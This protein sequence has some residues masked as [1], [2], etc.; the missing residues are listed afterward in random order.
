[1]L[2]GRHEEAVLASAESGGDAARFNAEQCSAV[3]FTAMRRDIHPPAG[4]AEL[5]EMH[6]APMLTSRRFCVV[7]RGRHGRG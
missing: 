1:M 5:L 3:Q 2:T 4:R 6:H 7:C